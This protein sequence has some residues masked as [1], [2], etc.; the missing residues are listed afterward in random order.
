ML[1]TTFDGEEIVHRLLWTI[2][3]EQAE[4]TEKRAEGWF[5]P[6]IVARVFAYHTIEAYLNY[7]GERIAP[8]IWEDEWNYFRKDPYR[9]AVGKLRKVMD[10]VGMSWTPDDRPLKTVLALKEV[11][12]LIAHGKPEK[13]RGEVIH[14][15]DTQAPYPFSALHNI[16][17]PKDVL[18]VVMPDLEGFL[19][20]AARKAVA[21]SPRCMVRR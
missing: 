17:T 19:H 3:K 2:V 1:K 13:L 18:S 10:L 9:G 14:P 12:D 21:E 4:E 11:R 20:S 5:Y 6:G 16:A 15:L 8:E 7:V